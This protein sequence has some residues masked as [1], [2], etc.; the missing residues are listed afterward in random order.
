M[1][2]DNQAT[3][4]CSKLIHLESSMV[5]YGIYNTE[6]LE[7]LIHTIHSMHNSTT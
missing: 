7:N 1:E 5:V 2:I 4:H 6:P 3:M